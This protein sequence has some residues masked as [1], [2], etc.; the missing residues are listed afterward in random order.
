MWSV[1]GPD[2]MGYFKRQSATISAVSTAVVCLALKM[3]IQV[4]KNTAKNI[5]AQGVDTY[6]AVGE[7]RGAQPKVYEKII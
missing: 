5:S 4:H 7:I 1:I 6:S 2:P 3:I